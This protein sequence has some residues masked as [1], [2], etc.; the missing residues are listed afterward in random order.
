MDEKTVL[1]ALKETENLMYKFGYSALPLI[2][3]EEYIK[4]LSQRIKELEDAE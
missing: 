2:M 4:N 1:E 3:I